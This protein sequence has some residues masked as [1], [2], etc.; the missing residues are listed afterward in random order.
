MNREYCT[1]SQIDYAKVAVDRKFRKILRE[2]KYL[3]RPFAYEFYHQLRSMIDDGL[4]NFGGAVVQAE[5]DKRY[6]HLLGRGRIPDFIIHSPNMRTKNL[7]VMEFKLASNNIRDIK[8]DLQKLARFKRPSL[9]YA[10]AV[11]VLIGNE[12]EI[13]QVRRGL[14]SI[15]ESMKDDIAVVEFDTSSWRAN[16]MNLRNPN[17]RASPENHRVGPHPS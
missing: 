10:H 6:Q 8:R 4:V 7:A 14:Q 12:S 17:A 11:Q 13:R 9:N 16:V 1:L 5:V 2:A 3:E 15:P